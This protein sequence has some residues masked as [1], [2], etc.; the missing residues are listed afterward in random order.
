MW[1][2]VEIVD[3]TPTAELCIDVRARPGS[4]TS[5]GQGYLVA[6]VLTVPREQTGLAT[7]PQIKPVATT[8]EK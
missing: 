3:K 2:R 1:G 6:F 8:A 7:Y 4:L 5:V